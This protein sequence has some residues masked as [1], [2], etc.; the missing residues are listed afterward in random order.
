[1]M[2]RIPSWILTVAG[3]LFGLFHAML[4]ILWI[5]TNDQPM[6]VILALVLYLMALIPSVLI[7]GSRRLPTFQTWFN[8]GVSAL[9][10]LIINSQLDP[11]HLTDYATWYVLGVGTLLGATA[12]RGRRRVAWVGLA[13]LVAEI[14]VWGGI[15]SLATT[16]LPGVFSLV[17]TGH[18]VSVGVERAVKATA[19]L[20]KQAADLA[21]A[22]AARETGNRVRSDLL[23]KTLR[24]ALPA[25]N[26][27]AALGGNLNEAQRREALLLEAGLRDEIRGANL[28]TDPMRAAIKA[29]RRRG[30]EVLVM[31]EGGLDCLKEDERTTLLNKAAESIAVVEAGRLTIRAPKQEEWR[32]TV[33]A[34]R[35]GESKP[36]L[37]LKLR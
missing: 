7:F 28:L 24:T 16:G 6:L 33:V 17:V 5:D 27:I 14:A 18:A 37:W 3:L 23:E 31:D 26:L 21:F 29:A 1:M 11:T 19:E 4:G 30:I 12:V 8:A 35:P 15:G 10:P 2:L 13:I 34:V 36:D 25:L 32:V 20:N 9:I 22:T